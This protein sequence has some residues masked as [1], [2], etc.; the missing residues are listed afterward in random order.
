V[1]SKSES[2]N[3]YIVASKVIYLSYNVYR[4]DL[5]VLRGVL[6]EKKRLNAEERET[7]LLLRDTAFKLLRLKDQQKGLAQQV[8]ELFGYEFDIMAEKKREA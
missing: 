8:D 3:Y 4:N 6:D 2:Y 5:S 7:A 1:A